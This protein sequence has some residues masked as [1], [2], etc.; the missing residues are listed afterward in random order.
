M[1]GQNTFGQGT[2]FGQQ[3]QPVFGGTNTQTPFGSGGFG[4]GSTST[5]GG[6]GTGGFGGF[7][8]PAAGSSNFAFGQQGSLFT[9]SAS[10]FGNTGMATSTG[11]PAQPPNGTL[12]PPYTTTN[13]K[14]QAG[15]L[16]IFHSISAMP[17]YRSFSFEELHL[18]DYQLNHKTTTGS[19]FGGMGNNAPTFGAT[20]T[21]SVFG[22]TAGGGGGGG[23]GFSNQ[24]T[25]F[26]AKTPQSFGFGGNTQTPAAAGFGVPPAAGPSTSLFGAQKPAFGAPAGGGGFGTSQPTGGFGTGFGGGSNPFGPTSTAQP[27]GG[28]F[29]AKTQANTGFG[30]GFG[31]LNTSSAF[32]VGGGGGGGGFGNKPAAAASAFG[33]TPAAPSSFGGFGTNT[34]TSNP[35]HL[36]LGFAATSKPAF[37][38]NQSTGTASLNLFTNSAIT[39][40]APS[41]SLFTLNPPA[42]TSAPTLGFNLFNKSAA[43]TLGGPSLNLGQAQPSSFLGGGSGLSFGNQNTPSGF[44]QTGQAGQTQSLQASI[45]SAPYGNLS[46]FQTTT[47]TTSINK[48]SV[49]STPLSTITQKKRQISTPSHKFS[50][51]PNSKLK[52]PGFNLSGSQGFGTPDPKPLHIFDNIDKNQILS[53]DAFTKRNPRKLVMDRRVEPEELINDMEQSTNSPLSFQ[54][55]VKKN[56]I[57]FDVSLESGA[58]TISHSFSPNVFRSSGSRPTIIPDNK[59]MRTPS[60]SPISPIKTPPPKIQPKTIQPRTPIVEKDQFEFKDEPFTPIYE[61]SNGYYSSPPIKDLMEMSPELLK[62]VNG[63]LAGRS[64]YG[65]I[66]YP[67]PV[68]LS[69]IN[70]N[71]LLG[72]IIRFDDQNCTVYGTEYQKPP[73]GQ[74]LNKRA[75]ITLD[76]CWALDKSDRRPI[77]DPE[78]PRYRQ[79][80][81]R[82]KKITGTKYITFLPETGSWVFEVEHFTTYGLI[83][84]DPE[85][86][87]EERELKNFESIPEMKP[88]IKPSIQSQKGKE[89]DEKDKLKPAANLP[90]YLGQDPNDIDEMQNVLFSDSI[91]E[92]YMQMD[93]I[94]DNAS[95]EFD[96]N[97]TLKRSLGSSDEDYLQDESRST[98]TEHR[99]SFMK[100]PPFHEDIVIRLPSKYRK[101]VDYSESIVYGKDNYMEDSGLVMGRSF[102]V[103]WGPNGVLVRC[104]KV[105]GVSNI[106]SAFSPFSPKNVNTGLSNKNTGMPNIIQFEKIRLFS[107]SEDTEKARHNNSM[108]LIF[109]ISKF[110]QK[111]G[112]PCVDHGKVSFEYLVKAFE[113]GVINRHESLI[114]K[115]G[116]A[117]WDDVIIPGADQTDSK[118]LSGMKQEFRKESISRWFQEAVL[119]QATTHIERAVASKNNGEAIFA[120]LT[121]RN[122]V[123]ASKMAIKNRDFRLAALLSQLCGNNPSFRNFVKKQIEHWQ[124]YE[125][126]KL[127]PKD[128]WKIYEILAGNVVP[129]N[130]GI[131]WKRALC[132]HLW[133][134]HYLGESFKESFDDYELARKTSKTSKPIPWY[135]EDFEPKPQVTWPDSEREDEICDVHYHMLKIYID[136]TH[137]LDDAILP[138]SIT[139]SPLDYRVTW[140]L[141]FMLSRTLS[142]RH[143][144]NKKPSADRITLNLM[145]QL[146]MLGLWQWAILVGLFIN[147]PNNRKN[148]ICELL[149]RL[150]SMV[151]EE[152]LRTIEKFAVD[153]LKIPQKWISKA[154]ALFSKYKEES[155]DEAKHLLDAEEF[156]DA[157]KI[158]VTKIAP[159]K[160]LHK[161]HKELQEILEKIDPSFVP[162]WN[163]GGKIFLDYL[164]FIATGKVDE[165]KNDPVKLTDLMSVCQSILVGLGKIKPINFQYEQCLSYMGHLTNQVLNQIEGCDISKMKFKPMDKI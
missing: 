136:K 154:K 58:D 89:K 57:P 155:V 12:N 138:R 159:E 107:D 134:G 165:I 150:V 41:G 44:G 121:N 143:F 98:I 29:G 43:P 163:L 146:E 35:P 158:V 99:Q 81:E 84:D 3:T 22:G 4:G 133:Y 109:K 76:H 18:L 77:K 13:D 162:N 55:P 139:L 123:N 144:V 56:N 108:E 88:S 140:M 124:E 96:D 14:D 129:S 78:D 101:V 153:Q 65:K 130:R 97:I 112:M 45:T 87:F 53:P 85:D 92:D 49:T 17:Q 106:I 21:S 156:A 72:K 149:N 164:K 20:T 6:G 25:A 32:G 1:F 28:L 74:G 113:N 5:G 34:A 31:N 40:S 2:G 135:K 63:F 125:L 48:P 23:G 15:S 68:D 91:E 122:I 46:I 11:N 95:E 69:E 157:H 93:Y 70:L 67:D 151:S 73:P 137:S 66:E 118:V 54:T 33:A 120:Y 148:V 94:G 131:D 75:V 47:P 61:E 127:I 117:L 30:G 10:H 132:M 24:N 38:F 27:T 104:S 142:I 126:K 26:G 39:S 160:I 16:N 90:E 147:D 119:P 42:S 36:N 59:E 62:S 161:K 82:L 116:Q 145:N 52:L 19:T 86:Q 128:H 105:C 83:L 100:K 7:G 60:I 71:D 114:W 64:N 51:K 110:G 115:L 79:R 9:P 152:Q 111:G 37:G 103:G 80:I 50:P 102:R 141:H 8:Q